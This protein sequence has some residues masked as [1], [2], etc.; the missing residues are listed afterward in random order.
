VE[1]AAFRNRSLLSLLKADILNPLRQPRSFFGSKP[2]LVIWTL[3]A[4]TYSTAN[5]TETLANHWTQRADQVFV[6]SV[7]FLSTCLVNVPLGVWKDVR[8]VQ[9]FAK[10]TTSS[11]TIN[12]PTKA[13]VQPCRRPTTTIRPVRFPKIVGATFLFRDAITIF[14]SMNLPPIVYASMPDSTFANPMLKMAALQLSV[15]FLSQVVAT[16][17]HLLGLY[18]YS[19]PQDNSQMRMSRVRR[20]LGPNTLVRCAR[21]I[22]AFGVGC[23]ANTGIRS[24]LHQELR[25]SETQ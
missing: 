19:H 25:I 15:P 5:L 18:M 24:Y 20:N 17:M 2:L 9:M 10:P 14:G 1:H 8:F 3:Y 4:A 12:T 16:P 13:N 23:I 22:P 6:G 7:T 21:I 11:T